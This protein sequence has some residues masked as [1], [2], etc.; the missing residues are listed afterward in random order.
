[1]ASVGE[2]AG[3]IAHEINTP[4]GVIV[5][6]IG[7]LLSVV[8][9]ENPE[10]E[11]VE[12]LEAVYRQAIRISKI[13]RSLL[14]Y[15]RQKSKPR[16]PVAVAELLA[17]C[18][19]LV[20]ERISPG[21]EVASSFP[22]DLPNIL[23]DRD[24]IEFVF[25][26][27]IH[28]AIDAMPEGGRLTIRGRRCDLRRC[29]EEERVEGVAL[30]VSDTGCGIT[31]E[32]LQ[33]IFDPFFTTKAPG[34]GTGLGLYISYEIINEHRGELTVESAPGTGSTFTV[35]LPAMERKTHAETR[36]DPRRR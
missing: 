3:G 16:R 31:P 5:T 12:D 34:R 26:N 33:K 21:I 23:V 20:A 6:R 19:E 2:L 18:L 30:S 1:M 7:Y 28:N 36:P 15:S 35:T 29:P 10:S 14:D 27:L 24:R 11:I 13:I 8:R 22:P 9:E 4:L 17:G 25:L 32:N